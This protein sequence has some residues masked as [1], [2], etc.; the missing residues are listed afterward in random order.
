LFTSDAPIFRNI[1][2]RTIFEIDR[3]VQKEV[4]RLCLHINVHTNNRITIND[5]DEK[6]AERQR[7]FKRNHSYWPRYYHWFLLLIIIVVPICSGIILEVASSSLP[8]WINASVAEFDYQLCC[9]FTIAGALV[10]WW[11]G[12]LSSKKSH[13]HWGTFRS[14]MVSAMLVGIGHTLLM[15]QNYFPSATIVFNLT[16]YRFITNFCGT[17][18]SFAGLVD[19]TVQIY[20]CNIVGAKKRALQNLYYNWFLGLM[21]FLSV[22]LIVR[23]AIFFRYFGPETAHY[24]MCGAFNGVC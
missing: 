13:I 10:G 7:Q 19:D 18:S 23:M 12:S 22:V 20:S 5:M 6:L 2:Q 15:F 4:H 8:S 11:I 3:E 17:A 21:L 14:N 16:I 9:V 1:D 24:Y